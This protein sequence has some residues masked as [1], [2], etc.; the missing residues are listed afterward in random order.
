MKNTNVCAFSSS[1]SMNSAEVRSFEPDGRDAF[2]PTVP[3]MCDCSRGRLSR[4]RIRRERQGMFRIQKAEF[5]APGIKR[6]VIEARRI[7]KKTPG[8]AV[9]DFA[10]GR[11]RG[12]HSADD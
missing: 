5:I 8:W 6:F 10:A 3:G 2:E 9:S 4:N 1:R 12:A 11:T 7:A